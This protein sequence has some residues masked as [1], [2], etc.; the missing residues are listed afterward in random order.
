MS[1][2][3]RRS[4]GFSST[5][6]PSAER[7]RRHCSDDGDRKL[8]AKFSSTTDNH[9]VVKA[10]FIAMEL[11]RRAGLDVPDVELTAVSGKDVLLVERFDR[12]GAG[13]RRI[14]VSGLTILELHDAHGI[15]GRYAT[16]ADLADQVR[17]RFT[18][19]DA[20]LRELFSRMTFNVLVGNTDD[21]PRNHAA[22]WDG[23]HLA[24][25]PAYDICP[26]SRSG[27]E[28]EQAMAFGRDGD[29]LSQVARC[30]AHAEVFH[31]SEGEAREIVDRQVRTIR[32]Q[33]AEVCDRAGASP[34]ERERLWR[35]QF[36]NPFALY[37]FG[38]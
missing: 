29:R 30:V 3:P 24:L 22:F 26:Q 21:H 17:A 36:L 7:D 4:T 18:D 10:E 34:V 31:L 13:T 27:E 1:L 9:P 25:T 14:M 2:A 33:W 32:E 38:E 35:R 28:A 6:A 15:A 5:A 12:P 19:A 23:E 16:Y 8:I 20:T 11:G 37:G